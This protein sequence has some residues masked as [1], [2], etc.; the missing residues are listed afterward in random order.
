MGYRVKPCDVH[1]V[2]KKH[3]SS[4]DIYRQYSCV[5]LRSANEQSWGGD[6]WAYSI[7]WHKV[8]YAN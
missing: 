4:V 7:S 1:N 6:V 2:E 5:Q 3:I 8:V